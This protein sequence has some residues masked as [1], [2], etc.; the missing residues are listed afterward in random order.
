MAYA[1]W[2]SAMEHAFAKLDSPVHSVNIVTN[3][4]VKIMAFAEKINPEIHVANAQKISKAFDAK[5]V[6]AKVSALDMV[7]VHSIWVAHNVNVIL[8]TGESSASQMNVLTTVKMAAHAPLHPKM[9]KSAN[10]HRTTLERGAIHIKR[11]Q[12]HQM[13]AMVFYA[14]TA[15]LV[16]L[17]RMKPTAIARDSIQDQIVR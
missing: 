14:I 17:S 2:N 4:S 15:A 11:T 3:C 16:M 8:D 1:L 12:H 6:R 13:T 10:V 7:N 9:S 5:R